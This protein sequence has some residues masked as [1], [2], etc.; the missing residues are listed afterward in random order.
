MS[1]Y[2]LV[3]K[4]INTIIELIEGLDSFRAGTPRKSLSKLE[5]LYN[6]LKLRKNPYKWKILARDL[7]DIIDIP[8]HHPSYRKLVNIHRI[9]SILSYT[10][11]GALIP[12]LYFVLKK[13]V[14]PFFY[15]FATIFTMTNISFVLRIYEARILSRI[16]EEK[17][18]V[19][20]EKGEKL[21]ETINYLLIMLRRELRKIHRH[22]KG[23]KLNLYR[24]DYDNIQ[25][26]K[27]P[28][29]IRSTYLVR[30]R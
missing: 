1:T 11:M 23:V 7:K 30:V 6:S 29:F 2:R 20:E 22:E 21:K 10:S 3:E 8:K 15:T 27:E 16:Y 13:E 18:D 5:E 24:V 12:G 17:G 19:L 9:A 14:V 4:R 26:V 25:V 28:S